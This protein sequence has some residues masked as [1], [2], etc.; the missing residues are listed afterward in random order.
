MAVGD[1]GGV[2]GVGGIA[3]GQVPA[4]VRA[5]LA[6]VALTNAKALAA[7]LTPGE[8][9]TARV[10]EALGNGN[11]ALT[12]RGQTLVANS[13]TTLLPDSLLKLVV[14]SIDDGQP[15]LRLLPAAVPDAV[16][17][18]TPATRAAA[19]GLP[20][21][22][23]A[24]VALQAFEQAGAPLDPTRL[25]DALAQLQSLSPAQVPQRAQALALL[26]Q[27][28]L[29]VTPP[30]I[31]L[32]ERSATGRLPNP[33]A[34][35]AEV[36]RL[37]QATNPAP[38]TTPLAT[39]GA[40]P[41]TVVPI[42]TAHRPA[43]G[44]PPPVLGTQPSAV[45]AQGL[46]NSTPPPVIGGPNPTISVQSSATLSAGPSTALSAPPSAPPTTTVSAAPTTVAASDTTQRPAPGTPP[47]VVSNQP[48]VS[49]QALP[50]SAPL[51]VI[52]GSPLSISV[53]PPATTP[54]GPSPA[55]STV[56]LATP[57]TLPPPSAPIVATP[58]AA[59][60]TAASVATPTVTTTASTNP[61]SPASASPVPATVT[62]ATTIASSPVPIRMP[63]P[64]PM[65][66]TLAGTPVPDLA[67]G[68][69]TAVLQALALA[70]V[71]PRETGEVLGTKAEPTLLH[72]LDVP[73]EQV[74]PI[75]ATM[76][77]TTR[78]PHQPALDAAMIHVMREQAAE[79]VVKPQALVD[80]DIVLGLPL[81]V[82]GQPLPARLAVAERKTTAGTATF[83]RVDAELSYLGPLSV[84]ISGI[85]GGPMAIT[86]F[87][88]GPALGALAEALPDLNDSLR[89]LGLTAGVRVADLREDLD[90]G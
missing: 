33:A 72:R 38:S 20:P 58:S 83:L 6:Q 75:R 42:D 81:Q 59:V 82:N 70:G 68:G 9:L 37:A 43:V 65:T 57:S 41:T 61:L 85:E 63:M 48:A 24:S 50:T 2:G 51:P 26:A 45:S 40:F 71:R 62:P 73:V 12:V 5:L 1:L 29:P 25:K 18:S 88:T 11:V 66:T 54:I 21:T 36:Q 28:G 87:G 79:T 52:G 8:I 76:D 89:A 53:P 90:H 23:L 69:A 32:A 27:A 39:V 46:P 47:S 55:A 4:D 10:G 77:S 86:V 16:D 14:Q 13:A 17:T 60:V 30:F 80:Y 84:R 22:A 31:A 67:R 56:P 3:P 49:G 35:V 64:V 19:V 15:L 74:D 7:T 34:A 44:T 78:H